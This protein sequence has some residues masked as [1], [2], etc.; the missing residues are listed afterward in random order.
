[1][2][3]IIKACIETCRKCQERKP[4]CRKTCLIGIGIDTYS[5]DRKKRIREASDTDIAFKQYKEE[6]RT[7]YLKRKKQKGEI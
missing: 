5:A 7:E 1:M 2:T 6:Q 3:E 4:G